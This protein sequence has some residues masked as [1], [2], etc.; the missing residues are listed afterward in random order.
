MNQPLSAPTFEEF[1]IT[2]NVAKEMVFSIKACND[3]QIHFTNEKRETKNSYY[4]QL[5]HD[6]NTVS[7]MR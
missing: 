7:T 4:V 6:S 3:A 2:I 5:G 1:W